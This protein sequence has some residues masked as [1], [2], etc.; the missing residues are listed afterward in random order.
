MLFS[1]RFRN[2]FTLQLLS[3]CHLLILTIVYPSCSAFHVG[4]LLNVRLFSLYF[5]RCTSCSLTQPPWLPSHFVLFYY[6]PHPKESQATALNLLQ[7]AHL[8]IA[9]IDTS[10]LSSLVT[11]RWHFYEWNSSRIA[12]Q[13]CGCSS[14]RMSITLMGKSTHEQVAFIKLMLLRKRKEWKRKIFF[15]EPECQHCC[16]KHTHMYHCEQFLFR[17]LFE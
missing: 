1:S 15:Y 7:S 17:F 4:T 11:P 8:L 6:K 14:F 12:A 2:I 16:G 9:D 3:H 5:S 13:S 10:E